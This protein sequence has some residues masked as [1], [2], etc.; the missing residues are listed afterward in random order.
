MSTP[1]LRAYTA[2]LRSKHQQSVSGTQD[3]FELIAPQQFRPEN[4]SVN[5]NFNISQQNKRSVHI[6]NAENRVLFELTTISNND[7]VSKQF[8]TAQMS[9]LI[10]KGIHEN[11]QFN[12]HQNSRHQNDSSAMNSG[13]NPDPSKIMENDYYRSQRSISEPPRAPHQLVSYYNTTNEPTRDK[14]QDHNP[15]FIQTDSSPVKSDSISSGVKSY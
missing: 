15:E 5:E 6:P 2:S 12:Q 7:N 9:S 4:Q 10:P 3:Q 13:L 8:T 1:P 11:S 14:I